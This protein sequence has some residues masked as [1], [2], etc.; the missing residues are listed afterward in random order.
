MVLRF[1]TRLHKSECGKRYKNSEQT[2]GHLIMSKEVLCFDVLNAIVATL[3][4]RSMEKRGIHQTFLGRY[5]NKERVA[6]IAC[7][8]EECYLRCEGGEGQ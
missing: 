8:F 5:A 6:P 1:G 7:R 3:L 4:I 2:H